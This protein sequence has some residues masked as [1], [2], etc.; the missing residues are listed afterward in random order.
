MLKG[1]TKNIKIL[2]SFIILLSIALSFPNAICENISQEPPTGEISKD[3]QVTASPLKIK[4]HIFKTKDGW[5]IS[6][7]RYILK[8]KEPQ[9]CKAAVILCHGF[10]FNNLFWD[11]E[12]RVSLARYLAKNGYDVW[13][14]SLRGSGASSKPFLNSVRGIVALDIKNMPREVVQA[15]SN[16]GKIR[17]TIDDHILQ[18]APAIVNYVKRQSGFEKVYWVGHSMGGIIM[19]GYLERVA[20]DDIAGFIPIG[21]MMLIPKPLTPHLKKIADQ[22]SLLRASLI[23]NTRTAAQLRTYSLNKVKYP[24]E[25]LLLNR[26]NMDDGIIYRLFRNCVSDT[27]S[28]VVSQFANSI[29]QGSILSSDKSYNYSANINHITVPIL[30]LS[31][32][33][34]PFVSED[35]LR[36][37]YKKVSSR[38]KEI[39]ICSKDTGYSADYG[40]CD[41]LLGKKSKDEIYPVILNWLDER[42]EEKSFIDRLRDMFR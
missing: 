30:I 8:G 16:M 39:I 31:G 40:H 17:W 26:E 21:S 9:E 1:I 23:I 19:F 15:P 6:I 13:T 29:R 20:Q 4:E 33:A 42:T 5:E 2:F 14:P 11:L 12:K 10:N 28:G 24:I 27:S 38:D 3:S 36:E 41:L 37:Y 35:T 18:D 25:E 7:T 22:E 34:D 32:G